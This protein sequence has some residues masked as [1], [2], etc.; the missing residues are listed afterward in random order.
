[1]KQGNKNMEFLQ[2]QSSGE[3]CQKGWF[4]SCSIGDASQGFI[5]YAIKQ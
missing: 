1:M 5:N 4:S 3:I 2:K